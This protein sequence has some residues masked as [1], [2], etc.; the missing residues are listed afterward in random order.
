MVTIAC[1]EEQ[2]LGANHRLGGETLISSDRFGGSAIQLHATP[3][4]NW[5]SGRAIVTA[6]YTATLGT[7][8]DAPELP[9]LQGHRSGYLPRQ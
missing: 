7:S 6:T 1:E 2:S 3:R 9:H 4:R 5:G 8:Q